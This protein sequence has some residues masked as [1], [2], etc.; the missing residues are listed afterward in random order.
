[1]WFV[2]VLY[3][4]I[5]EIVQKGWHLVSALVQKSTF[6]ASILAKTPCPTT[7]PRWSQKGTNEAI[8]S[9]LHGFTNALSVVL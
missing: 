1:V 5:C 2:I 6:Y 7:P 3:C 8:G 9:L 4:K